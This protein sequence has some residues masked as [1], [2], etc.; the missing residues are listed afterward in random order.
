M[1]NDGLIY[2]IFY[3]GVYVI[4]EQGV[5]IVKFFYDFYKKCDSVEFYFDVVFGCF[6]VDDSVFQVFGSDE[7]ICLI[8]VVYGGKG[9]ICQGVIW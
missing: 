8:V 7:Q 4:D 2:G 6:I 1:K 3:L 5:V 9:M